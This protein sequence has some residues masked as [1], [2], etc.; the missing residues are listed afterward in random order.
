MAITRVS[1]TM[2][3]CGQQ[4]DGVEVLSAPEGTQPGPGDASVCCGCGSWTVFEK[5]GGQRLFGPDDLLQFTDEQLNQMR[6][7]TGFIRRRTHGRRQ[8]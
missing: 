7:V 6:R 8:G 5:D 4:K 3:C 1:R 2:P